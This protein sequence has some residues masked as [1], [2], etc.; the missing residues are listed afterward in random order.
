MIQKILTDYYPVYKDIS[1][2]LK[3]KP[4]EFFSASPIVGDQPPETGSSASPS[5]FNANELADLA[6]KCGFSAFQTIILL[7]KNAFEG[8]VFMTYNIRPDQLFCQGT[9]MFQHKP[10]LMLLNFY[11]NIALYEPGLNEIWNALTENNTNLNGIRSELLIHFLLINHIIRFPVSFI[12]SCDIKLFKGSFL[13]NEQAIRQRVDLT[14]MGEQALGEFEFIGRVNLLYYDKF[15]EFVQ[16]LR[17]KED[18]FSHYQRKLVLALFPDI[19]T[20]EELDELMYKKLLEEKMNRTSQN[21]SKV[22]L[23]DANTTEALFTKLKIREKTKAIYRSVSKNCYEVHTV[24]DSEN[25]FP[26]LTEIFLQANSI[27]I[28]PSLLQYMKMVLLLSKAVIYRKNNGLNI[29][30]NFQFLSD[31]TWKEV[32]S[33]DDLKLIRRNL[34]EKLAEYR[35]RSQTEYKKKFILEEDLT[36]IHNH[37]LQKQMDY[38]DHQI[39]ETKNDIKEV[40]K[41]KS[42]VSVLKTNKN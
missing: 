29:A 14:I 32:V 39:A 22:H 4:S 38:M 16:Q 28:E 30:E 34:D 7:I 31:I 23:G 9:I 36:D 37:F 27:Y 26:V 24:V 21:L 11:K 10:E 6:M 42:K 13:M 35:L 41:L 40:L 19:D 1:D 20:E 15:K 2:L 8:H 5:I 12:S 3:N 18:V 25:S 17:I 33:K